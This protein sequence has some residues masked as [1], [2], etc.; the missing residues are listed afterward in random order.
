MP[1]RNYNPLAAFYA[2]V[3]AGVA[4]VSWAEVS[5][6]KQPPQEIKRV[7][8]ESVDQYHFKGEL[9]SSDGYKV[10]IKG[11]C[12]QIDFPS[13]NWNPNVKPGNTVDMTVRRTFLGDGL[14][15]LTVRKD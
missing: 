6:V 4:L 14:V 13:R 2:V 5:G 3:A 1:R 7:V 15:G 10:A 8:V 9:F 12:E 11:Q